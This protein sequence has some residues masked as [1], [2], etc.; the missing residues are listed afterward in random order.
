TVEASRPATVLL[1]STYDPRW[2]VTVDGRP[3]K[4]VMMAP[5]LVGVDVPAGQHVVRFKYRPYGNYP[6]LLAIG[7]VTLLGLIAVPRPALAAGASGRV[8]P[9]ETSAAARRPAPSG[10]GER[11]G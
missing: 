6:L 2:T 9:R 8:S 4:T 11:S 3:A 1:K 7:F 5:S 10:T